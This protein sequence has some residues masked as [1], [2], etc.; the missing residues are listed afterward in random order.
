MT[1]REKLEELREKVNR[2]KVNAEGVRE[3]GGADVVIAS[4]RTPQLTR[5]QNDSGI[6]ISLQSSVPRKRLVVTPYARELSWLFYQLRDIF[7]SRIDSLS[8]Y[9]FYGALAQAALD[10][11]EKNPVAESCTGLLNAVIDRAFGMLGEE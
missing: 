3:W 9:D 6:V 4:R 2:G 5:W 8:K 11:I 1:T 7:A 10:E